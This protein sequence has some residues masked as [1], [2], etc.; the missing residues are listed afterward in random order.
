VGKSRDSELLRELLITTVQHEL[1]KRVATPLYRKNNE[2]M[3]TTTKSYQP[4]ISISDLR[5]DE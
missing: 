1:N 5:V 2:M 4:R 3:M